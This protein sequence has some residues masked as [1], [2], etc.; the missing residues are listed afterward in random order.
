MPARIVLARNR[1]LTACLAAAALCTLG[2]TAAAKTVAEP[3]LD[4][5]PPERDPAANPERIVAY[6]RALKRI[7][8]AKSGS[9]GTV[10]L[11]ISTPSRFPGLASYSR[12]SPAS[13]PRS[14][15]AAARPTRSFCAASISITGPIS[16]DLSMACR[17]TCVRTST[18]KAIATSIS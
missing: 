4:P 10:G 17:S 6:C 5:I 13:S 15:Q 14:T 3:T 12:T 9:Q 7:G 18:D 11:P 2:S 1:S 16:P 8:I